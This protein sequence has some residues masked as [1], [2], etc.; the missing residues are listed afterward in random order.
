VGRDTSVGIATRYGLDG[1]G[2]ESRCEARF[3]APVQTGPGAHPASYTMCTV[4]FPVVKRP[5]RSVDHPPTSSA[6]VKERVE[7]YLYSPS[8][9]S[10]PIPGCPLPLPL[11]LTFK[12]YKSLPYFKS[13]NFDIT[14]A[15]QL[16]FFLRF[17]EFTFCY[18]DI[19][20][21]IWNGIW[22]L[23]L[24]FVSLGRHARSCVC[25]SC[26]IAEQ[27]SYCI[28]ATFVLPVCQTV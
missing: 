3:S 24:T 17:T 4:S 23:I 19:T 13:N 20:S 27:C 10:W 7:L 8:G 22:L 14:P 5:G 12:C 25:A 11:L 28:Q 26:G 21:L 6:E 16:C 2:I 9:P 15:G 18:S 1:P